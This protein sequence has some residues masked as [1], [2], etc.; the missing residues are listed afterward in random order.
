[1][2]RTFIQYK[3]GENVRDFFTQ[4]QNDLDSVDDGAYIYAFLNSKD[5]QTHYTYTPLKVVKN[6]K[7]EFIGFIYTEPAEKANPSDGFPNTDK[8]KLIDRG[9]FSERRT[10]DMIVGYCVKEDDAMITKLLIMKTVI[11]NFCQEMD[12]DG[13]KSFQETLEYYKDEFPEK[14]I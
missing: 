8:H 14:L 2:I 13:L 6:D 1:M 4:L 5:I 7:N 3:S 9:I 10:E 12:M 11:D